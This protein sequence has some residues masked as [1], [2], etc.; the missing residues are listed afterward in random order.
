MVESEVHLLV[1]RKSSPSSSGPSE[2]ANPFQVLIHGMWGS[3]SHLD[4]A[5]RVIQEVKSSQEQLVDAGAPD[6]HVLV[7]ATN[8]DDH[9]YDGIDNGGERVAKEVSLPT[10]P[11]QNSLGLCG[12]RSTRK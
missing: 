3:P 9:T 5:T 4:S 12:C 10:R 7:A 8:A 2:S 6:L 11:S 1:S